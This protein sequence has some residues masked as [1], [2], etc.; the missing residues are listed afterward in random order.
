MLELENVSTAYGH[1]KVLHNVSLKVE[2]GEIVTI[3][4]ANGSGKTTLL[5]TV[6]RLIG[7]NGGRVAFEGR[8]ITRCFPEQVVRLGIGHVP[9]G[10]QLFP[11]MSVL[12]N[13]RLGA[14]ARLRRDGRAKAERDLGR[15]FDVFPVLVERK[16]QLAG[17]LSGGEQQM[18]AIGRALMS[19]PRLML[20]D[21]PSMGLAPL[22]IKSIFG[23]L[24]DLHRE[25]LTILLVEQDAR[26]ALSMADRGYV[27]QNGEIVLS[28]TGERLLANDE[29][30]EI[31]FGKKSGS[32]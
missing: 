26:L 4:G 18:L 6:S 24:L 8:D 11:N 29:V 30:Q 9:S 5:A 14:Y 10:R 20:L 22:V 1:V 12:D 2:E 23:A 3:I 25:G 15:I 21:E 28:D 16:D 31:Y 17:R 32:E 7:P 13:L 19:K 27:L